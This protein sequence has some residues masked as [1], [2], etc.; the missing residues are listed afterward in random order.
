[1]GCPLLLLTST[2]SI[3]G[4]LVFG[5]ELG[6]ISGAL[7]QL[8]AEFV[9]LCAQQ[10]AL[11]SALLVGGLMASIVGGCLIDRC[12]RRTSMLLSNALIT[13]GSL[14][15]LSDSYGGLVVGRITVGFGMCVSSMSC[16]IFVSEMVS[17][18]RRGLLVTLYE[19]GITVGILAAY[20]TNYLLSDTPRGWRLMFGIALA[21]TLAQFVCI[22]TLPANADGC[23]VN[24]DGFQTERKPMS[25]VQSPA[26]DEALVGGTRPDKQLSVMYLFQSRDNMR[27]R[28]A[29]GLGLVIFQQLSG[30]PNILLYA[31]TIFHSLGFHGDAS[32]VLASVGL[33][34]VKVLATL[35][36]M[37]L[38]DRVGRRPLLIGGCAFMAAGLLTVVLLGG[39]AALSASGAC[40]VNTPGAN[41]TSLPSLPH[42]DP[43]AS[44]RSLGEHRR[45]FYLSEIKEIGSD[46]SVYPANASSVLPSTPGVQGTVVNWIILICIFASV[47]AYSIGFGPITWLVLSEI[48]PVGVRGRAFAFTNCFNWATHL[49]VTC[50]FLHV[51]DAI[52]LSGTFL[53]Y[54]TTCVAAGIFFYCM[55]PETMGK[56][57]EQIDEELSTNRVHS[58]KVCCSSLRRRTAT[59]KYQRVECQHSDTN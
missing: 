40:V 53:L 46:Y 55:L 25:L 5:Y 42:A 38:S 48:F 49:L 7:L 35:I 29:I 31:S 11:V 47:G 58:D 12:G 30:Q 36:S 59:V 18:D 45:L 20:A 24:R 2:V 41:H 51:I 27:R 17:P 32:A 33:G 22:C 37:V 56:T 57:L 13:A 3:L 28:T 26:A 50:S 43:T 44:N 52:G 4:G 9:L 16:C 8:K 34:L 54:G 1:M 6:I 15:V 10:E 39:Q 14:V 23:N 19:A 21:P